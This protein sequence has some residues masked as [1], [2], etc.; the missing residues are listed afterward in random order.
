MRGVLRTSTL[1]TRADITRCVWDP[2]REE[3]DWRTLRHE[4]GICATYGIC[5]HRKDGDVLNCANN[6]AA[7]PV[8][9]SVVQKLQDVCP[10][11]LAE[12]NGKYCCTEE[13][14]DTL[15]RQVR[16]TSQKM[17]ATSNGLMQLL[18]Q[19]LHTFAT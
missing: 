10:Q 1:Y 19:M 14:I 5:G 9:D 13:Q 15:S 16:N 18:L 11:L 2:I 6:T 8:S 3:P 7:Q 12:G 4:E 17:L